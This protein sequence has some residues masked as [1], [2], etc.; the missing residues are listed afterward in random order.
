MKKI[1]KYP[2][3][4][5]SFSELISGGYCY[6]DK[7]KQ[8]FD[9]IESSKYYFLSRPRR[10]GKSLM[11]ST[12]KAY[13][14]GK[15]SLFKGLAID[16]L[17][18]EWDPHPVIMLSMATYDKSKEDLEALLDGAFKPLEKEYGIET[19]SDK[20]ST[21]FG[22]IIKAAH[23]ITGKKVVILIDEYDA[24]MVA[25]LE[26]EEKRERMRNLLKS[27]YTNLKDMDEHIRFAMLTGVS[28][29]SRMTIFSGLNN[30]NDISLVPRFS[31]ICGM[32]E[33][34]LKSTFK[35]GIQSLAEAYDTDFNGAL[36]ILKDNYDGYHFTEGCP[37]IY[38]PFSLVL[39]L[40]NQ[41]IGSYWFSSGTP[42][43][44]I[45]QIKNSDAFLPELFNTDTTP[46][47]LS[48]IE[49]FRSNPVALLFQTG[50]LT[51]KSYSRE[52]DAYTLG[53]PNKEVKD[54]LC[55][56]LLGI[57]LDKVHSDIALPLLKMRMDFNQGK[58][59][60]AIEKLK[61]FLAGIPYDLSND[62]P[63]IYF[64]NNLFLI[65][66]ILGMDAATE[67][68]TS[69]GRIDIL[70]KTPKYLY[71]I[72]LKL[73]KSA[74]QALAQIDTREYSLPFHADGRKIIKIGLNFSSATR[75]IDEFEID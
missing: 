71:V 4:I 58:T 48:D 69:R 34:E 25:H 47:S 7:T 51:I 15:R 11:L 60:E 65:F 63:E 30:L 13:F 61:S 74:Q 56:A 22:A 50:Y 72:E 42:T 29:F 20:L 40:Y 21:R 24:P 27:V 26:N 17:T 5:Q 37:D 35:E 14:E 3:G 31:D 39:A 41:K 57:Y 33:E 8:I 18:D 45:N 67:W 19:F 62:K 28:R 23:E 12:I 49:T 73:N 53:I 52:Y 55:N 70:L 2:V 44:L 68:K 64:E 16:S 75:N 10:F 32:T 1:I 66:C 46:A 38:N 59:E 43:F 9:L 6:V 36:K 54:G